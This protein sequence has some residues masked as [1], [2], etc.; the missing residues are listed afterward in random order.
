M[1]FEPSD[2]CK[3]IQSQL[4]RFMDEYIYPNERVYQE[5]SEASDDPHAEPAVMKGIRAKAKEI[6]LWNLFLPDAEHGGA[7]RLQRRRRA[8][9]LRGLVV[10]G[11]SGFRRRL[12][13]HQ[14][15]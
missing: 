5:Q 3:A 15:R 14:R 6:G 2:R 12:A 9:R 8:H 7:D 13:E 1:D 11:E 4:E 10:P